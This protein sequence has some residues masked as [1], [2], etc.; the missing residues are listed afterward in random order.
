MPDGERLALATE[1]HLL[2]GDEAGG[3]HRVDPYPV[4]LRTAR[5]AQLLLGGVRHGSEAG[6]EAS[7]RHD[8][9]GALRGAARRIHLLRTM[10]LND[11][12]GVEE[13]RRPLRELH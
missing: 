1:E 6:G 7:A 5:A 12:D 11:L 13:L 3:A 9:R 8:L 2:V 10:H 4:D